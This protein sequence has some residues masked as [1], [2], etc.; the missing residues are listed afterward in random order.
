MKKERGRK[1]L[2]DRSTAATSRWTRRRGPWAAP[3][4]APRRSAW[5]PPSPCPRRL[6]RRRSHSPPPLTPPEPRTRIDR[7]RRRR[8]KRGWRL[9]LVSRDATPPLQR[10]RRVL[11]EVYLGGDRDRDSDSGGGRDG[12]E[13]VGRPA[14]QQSSRFYS[15]GG[16]DEPKRRCH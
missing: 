13:V 4:W 2:R 3:P 5:T 11:G 14:Q 9:E 7:R 10:R 12:P 8:R 1:A 6:R 15:R 16:G